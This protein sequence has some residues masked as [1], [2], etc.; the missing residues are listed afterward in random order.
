M[1]S[2]P[3]TWARR[4]SA[5]LRRHC[6]SSLPSCQMVKPTSGR[7]SAWRR[8]A[9]T[10]C[11]SSVDSVFRNLRRAGVLK[12]SSRTSTLVPVPRAAGAS[13]PL[14]AS[15]RR[16][17][18][19]AAVRLS[20]LSSDTE[21]IAAS[22]SPRKPI[23]ATFSSS[24]SE[25]ILLV[26]WR[27]SASGSSSAGMPAPSSSTS[28]A[29]MPPAVS[30]MP[31]SRAPASSALS[32]S[33]RTTEAGRSTTSP[34]AIWLIS[35]SGSSRMGRRG[36]S[37]MGAFIW[38]IV[39]RRGRCDAANGSSGAGIIRRHGHPCRADRFHPARGRAPRQFCAGLRPLG[40]CP[41]VCR[42]SSWRPGWW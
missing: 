8:T 27:R 31:I 10:Q 5:S 32:T 42:S 16:A 19:S 20:R 12:N 3:S 40:L 18:G 29:R 4:V 38:G 23:V 14:R 41:A 7:T 21:A 2:S 6:C 17:W 34:A 30:L 24:S 11:A 26:A 36:C 37:V 35:S 13:S 39:G 1:N 33:S 9:S 28:T 22:A 25:P 15:S